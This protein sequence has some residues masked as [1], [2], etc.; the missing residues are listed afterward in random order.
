MLACGAAQAQ[1]YH[2]KDA[3]GRTVYSDSPPPAGT[4]ASS[5]LK[6]PKTSPSAAPA[7][8]AAAGDPKAPPGDPKNAEKKDGP[9]TTAEREADY[10][11][12]QA[13]AEKKAKDDGEKQAA[14]SQRQ[15]RCA[16]LQQNVAAMQS[17]QRM[18]KFDANGQPYF[19]EDNERAADVAKAQQEMSAA[20]CG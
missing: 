2:Y 4:P 7:P 1:L 16:A 8:A 5:I 18:R 20:K 14:E 19:I 10:K 12:R 3:N 17:G 9:K 11:K 6:A 15:A 13:E